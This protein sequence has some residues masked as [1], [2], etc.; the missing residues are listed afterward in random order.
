MKIAAMWGPTVLLVALIGI[1]LAVDAAETASDPLP[2]RRP[3]GEAPPLVNPVN[4]AGLSLV[5]EVA[6]EVESAPARTVRCLPRCWCGRCRCRRYGPCIVPG[7]PAVPPKPGEAP[8]EEAPPE[9]AEAPPPESL[10]GALGAAGGPQTLAPNMIGDAFGGSV[11]RSRVALDTLLILSP[12]GGFPVTSIPPAASPVVIPITDPSPPVIDGVTFPSNETLRTA[13]NRAAVD[14]LLIANPSGVAIPVEE[15]GYISS[16]HQVFLVRHGP[17]GSTVY[18]GSRSSGQVETPRPPGGLEIGDVF[19]AGWYYDYLVYVD[20]PN[21]AAGGVVG[22]MKIAENTSPIP[23]DRLLFNYSFF[24]SVPLF[25]GGIGVHRFTPGFEKTF[26]RGWMSLELKMP[27]A[28]TLDSIIVQ[29]GA[30]DLSHGEFGNMALTFK[31]LLLQRPTWAISGGLVINFPTADDTWLMRSDGT[32]LVKVCN[33]AVHLQPFFGFL[34]TPND[35]F[36]AQGFLQWEVETNGNAV[37]INQGQGLAYVDDIHDA[38]FQYLDVGIGQWI[39]R[40]RSRYDRLTGVAWT[41]ELHW[42]RSLQPTDVVSVGNFRVGDFASSVERFNLT[43]GAHLE[44]FDRT[45][46]TVGYTVPLGGGQDQQFDGELRVL[47][48]RRFGPQT[49]ATRAPL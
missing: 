19:R 49:R 24:D 46:T 2:A 7:K 36:F 22:R 23:K 16:V 12:T 17:G 43:L 18:D 9:E 10:A 26:L 32:T 44:F 41:A 11:S 1:N 29:D 13:I 21:P 20:I 48:N 42:N 45:T 38:T 25:P 4:L 5:D 15:P 37:L 34:W 33:E 35:R 39:W 14:A 47:I 28:V 27:M 31:S 8:P 40:G 3:A 6:G 30:T